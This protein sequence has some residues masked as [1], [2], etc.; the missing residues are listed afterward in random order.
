MNKLAELLGALSNEQSERLFDLGVE[1][2]VTKDE[3]LVKEGQPVDTMYFI[4]SG[5]FHIT[6]S[7][8]GNTPLAVLGHGEIV[9]EMSFID[10]QVA[11]ASVI[12]SEPSKVLALPHG[13]LLQLLQTDAQL[14]ATFY[15][16]L[17]V[18]GARRLRRTNFQLGRHA[19]ELEQNDEHVQEVKSALEVFKNNLLQW[20][21]AMLKK[22]TETQE[23]LT[24]T[25]RAQFA[26]FERQFNELIEGDGNTSDM[27]KQVLGEMVQREILPYLLMTHTAKRWYTKPR[28]YAGD[29]FSIEMVYR[30][31]AAGT[32]E[33][34]QLIDRCFLDLCA[35]AAVRNRRGLL[36]REIMKSVQQASGRTAL[37]TSLA[38]GPAREVFDVFADLEDQKRLSATLIDMDTQALAFVE[39]AAAEKGLSEQLHLTAAN[40]IYLAVG[41]RSLEIEPQDLIYSIGLIDYFGDQLVI[42]LLNYIHSILRPGGRVILGNFHPDNP[43]K[44]LQDHVLD[45]QL[46]HRSE[47]DMD[48][49]FQ[50]SAFARPSSNIYFEPQRINLFAEC[51]RGD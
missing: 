42:K 31:Q 20:N 8:L 25:I 9:G 16:S 45:W 49:L 11:S 22:D 1:R 12:A 44:A 23:S 19:S 43:T 47:A 30:D 34:G 27:T 21:T 14:A 28:G 41:R 24:P 38:C 26:A 15:R 17:A 36:A 33:M 48:R 35:A 29:F 39:E 6:T 3:V 2:D 46:I 5:I 37:I 51:V 10:P 7:I 4:V 32:D 50:S 18:I 40:L 13:A